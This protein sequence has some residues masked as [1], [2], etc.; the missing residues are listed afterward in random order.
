MFHWLKIFTLIF[1]LSNRLGLKC[2]KLAQ[3]VRKKSRFE[4]IS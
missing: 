1:F 2:L 4:G 3:A